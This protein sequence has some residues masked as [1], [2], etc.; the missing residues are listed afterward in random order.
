[1]G[2]MMVFASETLPQEPKLDAGV[3][4]LWILAAIVLTAH[5]FAARHSDDWD[6]FFGTLLVVVV[7]GPII[8]GLI[9]WNHSSDVAEYEQLPRLEIAANPDAPAEALAALAR[10]PS[11]RSAQ[12]RREESRHPRGGAGGSRRGLRHGHTAARGC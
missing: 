2:S 6:G 4:T 12:K 3:W 1:M 11:T 9:L 7:L 5:A 8:T 10:D